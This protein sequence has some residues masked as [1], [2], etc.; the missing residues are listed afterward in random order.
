MIVVLTLAFSFLVIAFLIFIAYK[1]VTR[2]GET[3]EENNDNR[4]AARRGPIRP[5]RPAASGRPRGAPPNVRHRRAAAAQRNNS[6]DEEDDDDNDDNMPPFDEDDEMM[7]PGMAYVD[8]SGKK[9][10]VKKQRKL[11]MKEERKRAREYEL[12]ER[13]ERKKKAEELEQARKLEEQQL[14]AEEKAKVSSILC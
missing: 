1:G 9:M 12:Q 6:D 4:T 3:E 11:E 13:E 14:E 8:D 2:S 5:G 10:G 7:D